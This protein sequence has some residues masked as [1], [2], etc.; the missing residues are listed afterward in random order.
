[1]N[2]IV[3]DQA[4][5]C[6][7]YKDTEKRLDKTLMHIVQLL[8]EDHSTVATAESCTGGLLSAAITSVPGASHVFELGLCTY[9]ERMKTRFLD[10]PPD[11]IASQGVVSA[12]VAA[13]MA[14]GLQKQIG[15]KLCLSVTGIA[16][17]GGGTPEQP[18]GTVYAGLLLG[19]QLRIAPLQL[20]RFGL[21]TRPEIRQGTAV[22]VFGLAER[23]LMEEAECRKIKQLQS[24]NPGKNS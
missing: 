22:C 18:V 6:Q 24:K 4:E 5:L 10:V 1:M 23:Y 17:P 12:T 13:A 20:W 8:D 16:G 9:A 11:M 7:I 15:A 19:D 21:Q 2:D 3:L 14:R